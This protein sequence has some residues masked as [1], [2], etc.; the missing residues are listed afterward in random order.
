MLQ[1]S[2]LTKHFGLQTVLDEVE[3]SIKKGELTA[4][5]GLSGAG[6]TTLIGMLIGADKP[7]SGSIIIDGITVE[8]LTSTE[9]Q[10]YRK[11][12]GVVFQ[13]FKLI[14]ENV[15]FALEVCGEEDSTI[16]RKTSNILQR[17]GLAAMCHK[18]PHQLSGGEQQR[19]A[20]ARALVHSPKL[21]IA[22]EPTGNL[23][24]ENT[25]GIASLLKKFNIED[26]VTVFITTHD[27][28]FLKEISP[29]R[30][31]KLEHG[32]IKE[33]QKRENKK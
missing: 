14:F 8:G 30:V 25:K 18:F 32:K 22:D 15:A 23:D 12:I 20:I 4:I 2:K 26:E 10:Q 28:L 29:C 21:L 6:K 27:P 31:L 24:P 3:F 19:V 11:N 9:L 16:E 17:V 5:V 7:N 1:F 33:E 13:D